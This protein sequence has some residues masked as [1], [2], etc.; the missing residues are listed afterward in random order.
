MEDDECLAEF[1]VRKCDISLFEEALQIPE[2]FMLEQQSVVEGM[3][4][5]YFHYTTEHKTTLGGMGASVRQVY[6]CTPN[7]IIC[8]ILTGIMIGLL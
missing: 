8:T 5:F 6:S 1:R 4:G 7:Q 2:E 3:E